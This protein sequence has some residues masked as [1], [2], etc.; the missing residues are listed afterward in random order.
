MTDRNGRGLSALWRGSFGIFTR[1][2]HCWRRDNLGSMLGYL[3]R[4]GMMRPRHQKNRK[5]KSY[6]GG[7]E[8]KWLQPAESRRDNFIKLRPHARK[9]RGWNFGV[10]TGMKTRIDG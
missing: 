1:C 6:T 5:R 10:S 8:N 3:F 2:G 7:T 9:K 4:R